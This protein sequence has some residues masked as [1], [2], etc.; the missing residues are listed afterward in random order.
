M[1]NIRTLQAG[2]PI[3]RSVSSFPLD[4]RE[5]THFSACGYLHISPDT[6]VFTHFSDT[7]NANLSLGVPALDD[8]FGAVLLGTLV[9]LM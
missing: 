1:T 4:I 6:M 2:S 9:A 5:V 7:A 3:W 8:T